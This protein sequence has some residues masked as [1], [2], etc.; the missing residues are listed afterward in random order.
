MIQSKSRN[1]ARVLKAFV[2]NFISAGEPTYWPYDPAKIPNLLDFIIL[3]D[4]LKR[5]I[6]VIV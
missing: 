2:L 3:K 6:G 5:F 4:L 1:L